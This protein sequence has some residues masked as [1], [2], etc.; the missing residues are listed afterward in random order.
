MSSIGISRVVVLTCCLVVALAETFAGTCY[1]NLTIYEIPPWEDM[2]SSK[3]Y[4]INSSGTVCGKSFSTNDDDIA[5]TWSIFDEVTVLTSLSSGAESSCWD[6]NDSGQASGFSRNASGDKRSVRW[7]SNKSIT[8]MGALTNPNTY[9]TG[10]S[11]DAYGI[12]N[13]GTILGLAEIPNNSGNINVFH[14]VKSEGNS[15]IDLGTLNDSDSVN[16]FG[17]SISY[18]MNNYGETVGIAHDNFYR[19]RPFIHDVVAGMNELPIDPS[20]ENGEWYATAI[21]TH[22][23]IGGHVITTNNHTQ[24][25]YWDCRNCSPVKIAMPVKFPNGEIYSINNYGQMVG[26]MW[27]DDENPVEHA[28]IFDKVFGLRDLNSLIAADSDWTLV[29]ARDINDSGQI[30]GAGTYQ[31]NERGYMLDSLN[32]NITGDFTNDGSVNLEDAISGLRLLTSSTTSKLN[33]YADINN[34]HRLGL[35]ELIYILNIISTM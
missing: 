24:P 34:D 4:G 23:M 32:L 7:E 6:I 10:S 8:D 11:S 2:K 15:L 3:V 5:I 16:Q 35:Q 28:F 13:D 14:A 29:F 27:S 21:N 1:A 22:E 31:G 25:Y 33:L 19:F 17:Y 18:D 12:D 26:M 9:S 30:A 20:F